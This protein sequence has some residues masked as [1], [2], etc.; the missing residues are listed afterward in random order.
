MR[1]KGIEVYSAGKV[2]KHEWYFNTKGLLRENTLQHFFY[3]IN[4]Y[5][6]LPI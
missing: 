4:S 6:F 5:V 1:V 2:E 3:L